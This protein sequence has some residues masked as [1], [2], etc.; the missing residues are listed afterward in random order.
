MRQSSRLILNASVNVGS[1]LANMVVRLLVVPLT[2]YYIGKDAYG[3]YALVAGLSLYAP[4]LHMGMASAVGR[5]AAAHLV[6][7]EYDE[8]NAVVNTGIAYF[9]VAALLFV[10]LAL[11][12]AFFLI[13]S[14]ISNPE[15]HA[16]AR[17]CVI[18]FGV[19]EGGVMF[20]GPVAGVLWAIERFDLF[21]LPVP[22]FRIVRLAALACILPY[23]ESEAGIVV[24][25]AVMALTNFLPALAR[26]IFVGRYTPNIRF[27]IRLARRRLVWPLMSFGIGSVTWHWAVLMLNYLP[28]L[29]IGR[30]LSTAHIAEYEIPCSALLLINMLVQDVVMVFAPTA[31]KLDALGQRSDL[32]VLFLRTAKYAAGASWVGCAGIAILAPLLLYLWVGEAFLGVA[33]VLTLLA[34]GRILFFVQISS[35]YVLV[36]MGKQRVPAVIAL[37]LVGIMG[38]GQWLVLGNTNWGLVGVAGVTSAVLVVGWGMVIPIYACRQLDVRLRQYYATALIRPALASLPAALVWFAL[39]QVPLSHAWVTL[40]V[41]LLSGLVCCVVGWWFILFDDWDRRM[42]REKIAAAGSKIQSLRT[43]QAAETPTPPCDSRPR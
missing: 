33:P 21:S 26:R 30:H 14:F 4:Y 23:C 12:I 17:V 20:L 34:A 39:R 1:G 7:K 27:S 18:V 43:G 8:L 19:I 9:R 35:W 11:L 28:L 37:V 40:G 6:K 10:V 42:V 5:Y 16:V 41:A 25:T 2:V 36:G 31:S 32:K 3:V 38:V 29:V 13:D 24:V 22:V 15:F